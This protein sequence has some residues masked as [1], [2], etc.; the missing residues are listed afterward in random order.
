MNE[1][2][3]EEAVLGYMT[4]TKGRKATPEDR[5]EAARAIAYF[6]AEVLREAAAEL[7]KK[8]GVT[9]RAAGDLRRMAEESDA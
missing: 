3:V 1:S 6:R 9:N 7:N 4:A 5:S 8:Y 2:F